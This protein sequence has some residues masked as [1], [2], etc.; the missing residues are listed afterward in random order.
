MLLACIREITGSNL[1][2]HTECL[3]QIFRSFTQ[4]P[5]PNAEVQVKGKPVPVTGR[6]DPYEF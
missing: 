4:Y 2:R 5:Y 3:T 1:G 6:G